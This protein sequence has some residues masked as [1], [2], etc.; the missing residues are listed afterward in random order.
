[1]KQRAQQI[2]EMYSSEGPKN[3]VEGQIV[4]IEES[5]RKKSSVR[6]ITIGIAGCLIMGIGMSLTM[7]TTEFFA[8]GIVIGIIGLAVV[9]ANY[10]LYKRHLANLRE[11]AKPQIIELASHL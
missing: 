11:T 10:P 6:A 1:M 9:C 7:V 5:I 4:N 3:T 2:V 8:L